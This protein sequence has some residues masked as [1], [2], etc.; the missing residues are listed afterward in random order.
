M[1]K[2]LYPGLPS[3]PQYELASRQMSNAS[4]MIS[5]QVEDG[6]GRRAGFART[7][8]TVHYA[9]SLGHHPQPGRVPADGRPAEDVVHA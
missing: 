1:T 5:F 6:P 2:V 7:C 9:V 4:G 8:D 3:H